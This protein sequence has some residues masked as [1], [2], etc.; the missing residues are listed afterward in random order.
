M[1]IKQLELNPGTKV[2]VIVTVD[3]TLKQPEHGCYVYGN[4]YNSTYCREVNM[5]PAQ[6][7]LLRDVEFLVFEPVA[8]TKT[9]TCQEIFDHYWKLDRSKGGNSEFNSFLGLEDLREIFKQ[10]RKLP[11]KLRK[12]RIFGWQSLTYFPKTHP[13]NPGLFVPF[14]DIDVKDEWVEH[15]KVM[16]ERFPELDWWPYDCHFWKSET[17]L[18]PR[19]RARP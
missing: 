11:V 6:Y 7:D 14:M 4:R 5:G 3:R 16:Q 13:N 18:S 19:F 1:N 17:F 12:V 15:R 2:P 8:G 10:R 9:I